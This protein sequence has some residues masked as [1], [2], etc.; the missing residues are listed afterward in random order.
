MLRLLQTIALAAAFLVLCAGVWQEWAFSVTVR[1]MILA[2]LVLF[3]L[4]GLSML[5]IRAAGQEEESPPG[6]EKQGS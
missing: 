3:I 1:K 2:Y 4:G 5:A 6:G